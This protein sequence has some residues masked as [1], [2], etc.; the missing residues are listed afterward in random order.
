MKRAEALRPLSRD[1]HAALVAA[2]ALRDAAEPELARLAFLEFWHEHG[3]HHFRVEEE[4]LL[5]GWAL[6][7]EIDR[8]AVAR[9]L[10]DHLAIRREVLRLEAGAVPVEELRELGR[11]LDEHVRF[12]ERELFELIE[13]ALDPK[14]LDRLAISIEEAERAG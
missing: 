8:P 12:E 5:P 10:E 7:A 6:H 3:S 14:A 9:M 2:K 4:V 11:R 1:H 13:K